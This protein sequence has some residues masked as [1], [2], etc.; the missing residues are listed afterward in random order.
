MHPIR[1]QGTVHTGGGCILVWGV[2][3]WLGFGSTGLPKLV[4]EFTAAFHRFLPPPHQCS[5]SAEKD[6]SPK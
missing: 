4:I 3:L 1:Q 6:P 5:G 2:F